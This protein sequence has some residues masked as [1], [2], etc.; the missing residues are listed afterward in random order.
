MR[1]SIQS[2]LMPGGPLPAESFGRVA[3]CAA[4]PHPINGAATRSANEADI[5]SREPMLAL[6]AVA[7]NGFGD[8]ALEHN[9]TYARVTAVPLHAAARMQ[10]VRA[11]GQA[12][13]GAARAIASKLQRLVADY[14]RHN[15]EWAT[16]R[17]LAELD[18]R[19]LRD[20]GLDRSEIRSIARELAEGY[21]TRIRSMN[22]GRLRP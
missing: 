3:R 20:I 17:A 15:L 21:T 1:Y 11:I 22:A 13:A 6:R 18:A 19:A 2:Q 5:N 16:G 8:A 12:I 14:R 10:R 9:S 7:A 4:V